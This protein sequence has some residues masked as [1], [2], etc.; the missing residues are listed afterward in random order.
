MDCF[1]LGIILGEGYSNTSPPFIYFFFFY[2][3]RAS[4][5]AVFQYIL[6]VFLMQNLLKKHFFIDYQIQSRL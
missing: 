2:N 6:T 3:I 4:L 5:K 1:I